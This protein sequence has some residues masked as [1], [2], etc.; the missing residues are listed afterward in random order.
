MAVEKALKQP[1]T[2]RHAEQALWAWTAWTCLFG[3]YQSWSSIPEIEAMLSG[4]LQGMFE[5]T[6][7]QLLEWIIAGYAGLFAASAWIVL[8]IG[9]GK[10]WARNSLLWG[11]IIQAIY[12]AWPPY[13]LGMDVLTGIPDFGL[14]IYA[15]YLLYTKP[16]NDWFHRA[17]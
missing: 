8:K 7:Q 14:Q 2:V 5:I 13:H 11:F 10:N 17:G 12:T 3:I 4:Q 6:P 15:L 9:A 16:G 1:Q